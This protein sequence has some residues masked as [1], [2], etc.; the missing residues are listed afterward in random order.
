MPL[1]RPAGGL[2][3]QQTLIY[4]G[5]NEAGRSPHSPAPG[6]RSGRPNLN[7]RELRHRAKLHL[8]TPSIRRRRRHLI[9][10]TTRHT[11]SL[12]HRPR[13]QIRLV[14]V[15]PPTPIERNH[16]LLTNR[17]INRPHRLLRPRV[18]HRN[19]LG[20]PRPRLVGKPV[21]TETRPALHIT[22]T[23]PE[24]SPNQRDTRRPAEYQPTLPRHHRQASTPA[25]PND[26]PGTDRTPHYDTRPV[27]AGPPGPGKHPRATATIGHPPPRTPHTHT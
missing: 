5:L 19:R 24:P 3:R 4:A 21:R 22:T 1:A 25:P 23:Q 26:T 9:H 8:N 10:Q 18:H 17:H 15:R 14:L 13:H 16:Q 11:P 6:P 12:H 27:T 20:R 7:I 2:D